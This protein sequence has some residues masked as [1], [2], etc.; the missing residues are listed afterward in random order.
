M[1]QLSALAFLFTV[2][3]YGWG[4]NDHGQQ[5]NGTVA[6]NFR[7]AKVTGFGSYKI[8]NVA[9]GSSHSIAWADRILAPQMVFEPVPLK[10]GKD[11]LGMMY[12]RNEFEQKKAEESVGQLMRRLRSSLSKYVLELRTAEEKKKSLDLILE[13]L[14]VCYARDAL[15]KILG[16]LTRNAIE[17]ADVDDESQTAE[18]TKSNTAPS[19]ALYAKEEKK[20][21]R[22][23]DAVLS[24]ANVKLLVSL[25]KLGFSDRLNENQREELTMIL[26][27]NAKKDKEVIIFI[28]LIFI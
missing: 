9:C 10:N 1:R 19:Y 8:T 16:D 25:L 7:P 20:V 11:P 12:V 4:D 22:K 5:G 18:G 13:S 17:D 21:A 28:F 24:L 23:E 3:V 6:A 15:I 27:H 2:Q 26:I 14:R